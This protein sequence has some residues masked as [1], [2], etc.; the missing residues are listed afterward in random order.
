MHDQNNNAVFDWNSE[1]TEDGQ[2]FI[3]L[4]EGDY[5]FT[6]SQFERKWYEGSA[7]LP[8]CNMAELTLDIQNEEGRTAH[9]KNRL[10]LAQSTQWRVG[11]FFVCIGLKQKGE[12]YRP[13]W[14]AV[15]GSV[16][17][18]HITQRKYT[19]TS[20]E[21]RTTN[22]VSAYLRPDPNNPI[23]PPVQ[24]VQAPQA[25]QAYTYPPQP[26]QAPQNAPQPVHQQLPGYGQVYTNGQ[27]W[28]P[29]KF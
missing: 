11:Q 18:A 28:T 21:E 13:N 23:I 9:I 10:F 17:R 8:A 22:E 24:P 20:G 14:D 25:V 16:G 4:P 27:G 15:L 5:V 19:T 3:L 2:E 12:N 26:V 29:G 6:V 7:K 1:I